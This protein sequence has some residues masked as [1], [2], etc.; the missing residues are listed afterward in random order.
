MKNEI[1]QENKFIKLILRNIEVN[2]ESLEFL[3]NLDDKFKA[4][5]WKIEDQAYMVKEEAK[6]FAIDNYILYENASMLIEI[7]ARFDYST[8]K[9]ISA[10]EVTQSSEMKQQQMTS[11]HIEKIFDKIYNDDFPN[12]IYADRVMSLEEYFMNIKLVRMS[13]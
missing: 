1:L 4:V 13:K 5:Y 8:E 3:D 2:N 10:L 12:Q 7:A 11:Y 6:E 9:L